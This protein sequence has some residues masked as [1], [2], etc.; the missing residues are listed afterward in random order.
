MQNITAEPSDAEIRSFFRGQNERFPEMTAAIAGENLNGYPVSTINVMQHSELNRLAA[1][2]G[3]KDPDYE[4]D[5]KRVYAAA[6]HEI[7]ADFCDQWIPDNPLTMGD[8]GFDG[9][10]KTASAGAEKVVVDG[11]EI[12]EPEDVA[13]HLEKIAFPRLQ[14]RIDTF[15]REKTIR[16]IGLS[17]YHQQL[18]MGTDILKTGYEFI[19]FPTFGYT[20]YGY[21]NYFCAYAMYEDVIARHFALQAKLCRLQNEAAAEAYRRYEFPKLYRLDH[22]MTDSRSTLVSLKS[23]EK[24]WYPQLAYCLE[25]IVKGTDVRLI[26]HCDG[27]IMTMVPGLIEVGVKGFQGFQYEDGIDYHGLCRMRGRDGKPLFIWAGASV[28]TV[29][30]HGTPEDVRKHLKQLVDDHGDAA[31]TLASSSSLLPGVPQKNLDTLIE[32]LKYYKTHR[33]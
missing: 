3:M 18:E 17:E 30:P 14:H 28:T 16:E 13:E 1:R 27:A 10:H 15:D 20:T 33:N 31:L 9:D 19:T 29:L 23:L 4:K 12:E 7:G 21:T 25:P 6:Q 8:K 26:W 11:M 22:D 24:I 5:Y 32:G 2:Y